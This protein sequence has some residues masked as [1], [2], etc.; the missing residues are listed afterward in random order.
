MVVSGIMYNQCVLP[1]CD[2]DAPL[3]RAHCTTKSKARPTR[4]RQRGHTQDAARRLAR[5]YTQS[6]HED[7]LQ[8]AQAEQNASSFHNSPS[9]KKKKQKHHSEHKPTFACAR[10]LISADAFM[11]STSHLLFMLRNAPTSGSSGL[12]FPCDAAI[13]SR[14]VCASASSNA[15]LGSRNGW[16]R[17]RYLRRSR[18]PEAPRCWWWWW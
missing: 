9:A 14:Y 12:R 11:T 2:E 5:R 13:T 8:T 1:T 4:M 6:A 16:P 18:V 3:K 10:A 15:V 17:A 7:P